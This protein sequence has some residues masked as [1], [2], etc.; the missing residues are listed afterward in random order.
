[1]DSVE[2][3][4]IVVKIK[5]KRLRW[6]GHIMESVRVIIEINVEEKRGRGDQRRYG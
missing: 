6:F 3:V 4:S 1:V 2:V 5:E